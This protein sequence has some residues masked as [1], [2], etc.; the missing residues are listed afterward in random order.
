VAVIATAAG[1][2]WL[3]LPAPSAAAGFDCVI[4]PRKVLEIR[5]PIEGLIEKVGVDRG[6]LVRAGQEIA[7]L[8]TGVERIAAAIA[9]HRSE[10]E[11]AVRSGE[12]RVEY[13]TAKAAR[14]E[15]L[16]K[17]KFISAQARDEAM[18]E[19]N[20]AEAEL[21]DARDNRKL[22]AL[23]HQRQMELIRLK[24]IRSPINGVVV[25]RILN[26]GELAESGVG[27]KPIFKLA[28]ID[29]LHVEVLLPVEVYGKV[30]R[31]MEVEVVPEIPADARYR[32]TVAVI[33]RIVDAASGTFGVRLELANKK[34]LMPAGI[35]CKASFPGITA[36][37]ASAGRTTIKAPAARVQPSGNAGAR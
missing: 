31:G 13:S 28:E 22:A 9:K 36:S 2:L 4:E 7:V 23:E 1:A 19:K 32:A 21:R 5:A 6:D 27:R 30:T 15:Q 26:V 20:L 35:R 17:E 37:T 33:D 25:E 29:V 12:S 14:S 3:A 24:S 11:G 16:H 18:T 34:H 10:M 8:D